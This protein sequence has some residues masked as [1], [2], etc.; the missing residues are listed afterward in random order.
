MS[1]KAEDTR[2]VPGIVGVLLSAASV[3]LSS[4]ALAPRADHH[5]HLFSP[6]I[7]A[8]ISFEPIGVDDLVARLDEAGIKR[9]VVLS[10]A[11]MYGSPSRSVEHEYEK[12]KGEND[13][14]SQQVARFPDRLRGFCSINPLKDYA[15]GE[16][17]RCAKDPYLRHGLKLHFGNSAI[18]YH[19]SEHVARIRG[20]FRAANDYRMAIV[21]HMR[22]SISRKIPYGD[23]EARIFLNEFVAAAPD[24]PIQIAHLAGAGG[25]A[26][27]PPVDRALSVFVEAIQ[28][29]DSRTRHLYF[30]VATVA[31]FDTSADEAKLIA[32]RIRQLGPHRILYGSDAPARGNLPPREGWAAF[33][34]LPLTDAEFQIIATNVPPYLR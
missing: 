30:D 31:P 13:W 18:D 8:L 20:V 34:R 1:K 17:G 19:N 2:A 6:G 5:Q 22:A 14:T 32:S 10:V 24:V 11:Y 27:D 15:L 7:A 12:V 25:Y 26:A 23:D 21:V 4:N 3:C 16:I 9:A 29:G 28:K 33:R